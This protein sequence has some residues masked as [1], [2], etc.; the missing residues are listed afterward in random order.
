MGTSPGRRRQRRAAAYLVA[1]AALAVAAVT[2]HAPS[3]V[4]QAGRPTGSTDVVGL[5]AD[6]PVASV[7]TLRTGRGGTP[8][9]APA[10]RISVTGAVRPAVG[11]AQVPGVLLAAYRTAAGQVPASCHLP[12]S[13]LAAIGQVESGSLVGYPLDAQHRTSILGPV[14]DGHGFAAV[15]DT[16]HGRWDGNTTWDRAVG[17]MQFIPSTWA[18]F[19]VDGDG[20]GVADPQ[21]IED[22]A[23]SAAFYLCYGGRDLS[24][25]RDL[26]SA[27]LSYNHSQAYLLLVLTYQQ[28]F[29]GLGLDRST[30][31]IGLSTRL[32]L[33]AF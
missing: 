29:A 11:T 1:T 17:P 15:A 3:P 31:I 24:D 33:T 9:L 16:D 30:Q 25:V 28:R 23:L 6:Q 13:L 22:A 5:M 2:S 14:L 32:A 4:P 26:R 12:V 8:R 27:V 18:R 10:V 21:D 19:G 20:D 7:T